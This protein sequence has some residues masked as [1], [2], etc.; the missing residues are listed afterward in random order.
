VR[1]KFIND[2]AGEKSD[3]VMEAINFYSNLKSKDYAVVVLDELE[4]NVWMLQ[5]EDQMFVVKPLKDDS[6]IDPYVFSEMIELSMANSII[7]LNNEIDADSHFRRET[8][9][10]KFLSKGIQDLYRSGSIFK[11]SEDERKSMVQSALWNIEDETMA[12]QQA[13][14]AVISAVLSFDFSVKQDEVTVSQYVKELNGLK[15]RMGNSSLPQRRDDI[16]EINEK[17][18]DLISKAMFN[19]E[20]DETSSQKNGYLDSVLDYIFK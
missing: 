1:W 7:R 14:K 17:A 18:L 13:V 4:K 12:I 10:N 2:V 15:E 5:E 3:T 19:V 11:I 8:K 16:D 9:S 6:V 20:I